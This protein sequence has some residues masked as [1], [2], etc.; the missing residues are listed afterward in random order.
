MFI[1]I[2]PRVKVFVTE[3]D[4]DFIRN[5]GKESFRES[6]LNQDSKSR[7]KLLADKAVLVR[8]KLDSDVQYML[9]R[10]IRFL[11]DK[12]NEH[13]HT[14]IADSPPRGMEGK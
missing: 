13:K 10:K 8:K 3:E 7:A 9:N 2:A 1:Q 12:T 5:H 6:D 4:M 11:K 14:I